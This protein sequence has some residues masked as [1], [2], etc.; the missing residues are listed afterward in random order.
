[1]TAADPLLQL[2]AGA[3][4]A[5]GVDRTETDKARRSILMIRL[6]AIGDFIVWLDAAEGLREYYAD[7]EITLVG[8]ELW[9]P[10]AE[11]LPYFDRVL[12]VQPRRFRH[13]LRYRRSVLQRLTTTYYQDALHLV[14]RRSG[15]FSDADAIIR[16]VSADRKVVSTG[17]ATTGWRERWSRRWYTDV[18]PVDE[19][20][21]ELRRNAEFVTELGH[22]SFQCGLP[23]LPLSHLPSVDNLPDAYYVLF[24][25]AGAD[26]R[27]WPCERFAEIANRIE[28]QTGWTGLVCGGPGEEALGTRICEAA[29]ARLQNWVG[30]TSIPELASV[31][32]HARLL[33]GNETSAV[34]IATAVATPSVC[35]LGGGHYG[36]FLPYDVDHASSGRPVPRPVIHDMPCFGCDWN[37][38]FE[39]QEG[40]QTPCVDRITTDA[41]W[42]CV[43]GVLARLDVS[44]SESTTTG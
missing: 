19:N 24:P 20:A 41:V 44:S 17:D 36:R 18:L 22:R 40:D 7:A 6:D 12:P 33:V 14:H 13:H 34:H 38:H 32:A 3:P 15:S 2:G 8:N 11:R 43:E 27:R 21:M 25:G 35:I 42:Q 1:M 37:C 4:T 31:L 23:T 30:K 29:D 10:L 5:T 26:Y 28:Q 16:A 9:T 39:V